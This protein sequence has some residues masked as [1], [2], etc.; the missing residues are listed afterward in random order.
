MKPLKTKSDRSFIKNDIQEEII[1]YI[2]KH[3][4][5]RGDKQRTE[6]LVQ[7]I[8]PHPNCTLLISIFSRLSLGYEAYKRNFQDIKLELGFLEILNHAVKINKI[9]FYEL[10]KTY[11]HIE[12][13]SLQDKLNRDKKE[14]DLPLLTK[15]DF[16]KELASAIRGTFQ[17]KPHYVLSI[18][19]YSLATE[20]S[21]DYQDNEEKY[22]S[23]LTIVFSI[24]YYF[25][26]HPS[27]NQAFNSYQYNLEIRQINLPTETP[28]LKEIELQNSL[29]ALIDYCK[30][31][32]ESSN[33]FKPIYHIRVLIESYLRRDLPPTSNKQNSST[34]KS[35]GNRSPR[36]HGYGVFDENKY[37][38]VYLELDD[39]KSIKLIS[40]I[41][42]NNTETE[43]SDEIDFIDEAGTLL[44]VDES[45]DLTL[46]EIRYFS[47]AQQLHIAKQRMIPFTG[48]T[49][50]EESV[51][52]TF[53]KNIDSKSC[54]FEVIAAFYLFV[55][56]ELNLLDL[57]SPRPII[58]TMDSS[59]SNSK[60]INFVIET[61][62][63]QTMIYLPFEFVEYKNKQY[64]ENPN[65]YNQVN[66][67]LRLILD[68]N[69][70]ETLFNLIS[71]VSS[72]G[73]DTSNLKKEQINKSIQSVLQK[74]MLDTR[75]TPSYLAKQTRKNIYIQTDGN[76]VLIDCS[77]GKSIGEPN[78]KTSYSTK[79]HYTTLRLKDIAKNL[80]F[81]VLSPENSANWIGNIRC[82]KKSTIKNM[83]T[84]IHQS[85]QN[86]HLNP[87]SS[88][89]DLKNACL[90]MSTYT[91]LVITF[92]TGTRNHK[93]TY[94][95]QSSNIHSDGW[96]VVN[97]KNIDYLARPVY[98]SETCRQQIKFYEKFK[99]GL[100]QSLPTE[101]IH[102][103][104]KFNGLIILNIN[105]SDNTIHINDFY[106]T[107]A[108]KQV[109]ALNLPRSINISGLIPNHSR[110]FLESELR[111]LGMPL[112]YISCFLGHWQLGEE[113][114]SRNG[115]FDFQQFNQSVQS[116]IEGLSK[117]LGIQPVQIRGLS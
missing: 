7:F 70:H 38:A 109:T 67:A 56:L 107:T 34:K 51:L 64:C 58:I 17:T 116:H 111:K 63:H 62:N 29:K 54:K 22:L 80:P 47:P 93:K 60:K 79:Q 13:F 10:I 9:D 14:K 52:K 55:A 61:N 95:I 104:S 32:P 18:Y 8:S 68:K 98:L 50:S 82:P 53:V 1:A 25:Q 92:C 84:T 73:I 3:L 41:L 65:L 71:Q 15:E 106:R 66:N 114:W 112:K 87:H 105:P 76:Y 113:P 44:V 88:T 100:I 28:E 12:I 6:K 77:L 20:P 48:I 117:G 59:P 24:F 23:L 19:P 4:P 31:Y 39:D 57:N 86:I 2:N 103:H 26:D 5:S 81:L 45:G 115:S 83:I 91:D 46:D 108:Y 90:L 75:I 96:S 72:R 102:D 36:A 74:L 42:E 78:D 85:L 27:K 35:S 110:H 40:P 21:I 97:D 43:N 33:I 69:T 94:F 16:E 99:E 37:E 89:A 11:P 101:Q 30:K 49:P